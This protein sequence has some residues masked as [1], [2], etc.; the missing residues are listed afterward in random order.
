MELSLAEDFDHGV[1][2]L[3]ATFGFHSRM[4]TPYEFSHFHLLIIRKKR[5]PR[6]PRYAAYMTDVAAIEHCFKDGG[7]IQ[8]LHQVYG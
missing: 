5:E 1:G 6:N 2:S 8:S 3:V 4:K 7:E